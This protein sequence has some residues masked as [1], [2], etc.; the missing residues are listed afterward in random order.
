MLRI[1][2]NWG[3]EAKLKVLRWIYKKIKRGIVWLQ[4]ENKKMWGQ[5]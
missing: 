4:D 2:L 5:K 3:K 1:R